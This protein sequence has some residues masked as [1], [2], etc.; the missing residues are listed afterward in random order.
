MSKNLSEGQRLRF[1]VIKLHGQYKSENEIARRCKKD[2]RW[3]RSAIGRFNDL[4][5]F[6]NRPGQGRKQKLDRSDQNRLVKKVKGKKKAS[7]RKVAKTFKS[8]KGKSLSRE[9]IRLRLK[10]AGLYPH[11]K[12]KTPRLTEKKK[13]RESPSRRIT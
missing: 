5:H 13:R 7:T 11:K 6:G 10:H 1:N 2:L 12:Y 4:G 8:K 9:S 3:V